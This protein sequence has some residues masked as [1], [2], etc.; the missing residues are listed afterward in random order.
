MNKLRGTIIVVLLLG[1]SAGIAF[2]EAG[3]LGITG[4]C[5]LWNPGPSYVTND[6]VFNASV[7][8]NWVNATCK[9]DIP[10][11]DLG[12]AQVTKYTGEGY[13]V[14]TIWFGTYPNEIVYTGSGQSTISASGQV[15]IKCKAATDT[16]VSRGGVCPGS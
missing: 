5:A 8:D 10:D 6:G 2:G 4:Y 11:F 12:Q 14:C 3:T 9:W 13:N 16:C 15:T 7:N 1:L